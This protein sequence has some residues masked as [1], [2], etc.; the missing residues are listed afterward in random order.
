MFNFKGFFVTEK[1]VC[2]LRKDKTNLSNKN[3]KTCKKDD[4]KEMN[5]TRQSIPT[6]SFREKQLLFELETT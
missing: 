2:F 3:P 4:I 1:S 5:R 6:L